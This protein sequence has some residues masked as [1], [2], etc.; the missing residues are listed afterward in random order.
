[1][2]DAVKQKDIE[3]RTKRANLVY[4]WM[5]NH[6]VKTSWDYALCELADEIADQAITS[7]KQEERQ[8]AATLIRE[9][10]L[11]DWSGEQEIYDQLEDLAIR[12]EE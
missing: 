11:T 2:D 7:T 9:F 1:M 6:H 4:K 5:Q 10:L 12:V 8:R 3:E